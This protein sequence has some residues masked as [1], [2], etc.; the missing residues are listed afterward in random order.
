MK[1][2]LTYKDDKSDKFWNI[3]VSGTSFTVT[4][5]KTGT[6]GQT[7]TKTFGSEEECQKEAEKLLNEKLKKGYAEGD[8]ELLTGVL[9]EVKPAAN[10]RQNWES[11]SDNV[12]LRKA[13]AQSFAHLK[14]SAPFADMLTK[15]L[16]RVVGVRSHQKTLS[17][18]FENEEKKFIVSLSAGK[19]SPVSFGE[20]YMSDTGTFERE[21]LENTS[22][23]EKTAQ[24]K[25]AISDY[26]D[27]WLYHPTA[28]T[29]RKIPAI[30]LI[31][32][33]GGDVS[34]PY[35][36]SAEEIFLRRLAEHLKIGDIPPLKKVQTRTPSTEIGVMDL[37]FKEGRFE[38]PDFPMEELK[39][40]E[41]DI[42]VF[43][44]CPYFA[45]DMTRF[46]RRQ[47]KD[48]NN[49]WMLFSVSPDC[50]PLAFL[51]SNDNVTFD[52]D[53]LHNE[54]A[55]LI[56]PKWFSKYENKSVIVIDF[57]DVSNPKMQTHK[58][59][60]KVENVPTNGARW[61][62]RN[63]FI[64]LTN[65]TNVYNVNLQTGQCKMFYKWTEHE[66]MFDDSGIGIQILGDQLYYYTDKRV[67]V[68]D[69]T[70]AEEPKLVGKLKPKSFTPIDSLHS[71]SVLIDN[72]KTIAFFPARKRGL[73]LWNPAT[74][75]TSVHLSEIVNAKG[76]NVVEN[77]LW[78]FTGDI[79]FPRIF[80]VKISN[81]PTAEIL[82]FRLPEKL[83]WDDVIGMS[84]GK[85][86]VF[87]LLAQEGKFLYAF[88]NGS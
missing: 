5:G 52:Y 21:M 17:V 49:R 23:A 75:K 45:V 87:V 41:G 39:L 70:I 56:L 29:D 78:F 82:S 6:A 8:G 40:W 88:R 32:H 76:I 85:D 58:I 36:H 19:L 43:A 9:S 10:N 44:D 14:L 73:V 37:D 42:Y 46:Y 12:V 20:L 7:Q 16:D 71:K 47:K 53:C 18:E 3:E 74:N 66:D 54:S 86:Y 2:H 57:E 81:L 61:K 38:V 13:L 11:F 25:V 63:G 34:D 15:I 50:R 77:E 24:I 69:I 33:A 64:Y 26:A 84:V 30:C 65:G 28:K 35:N 22:L 68:Y 27:W 79:D 62:H 60:F 59:E 1:H 80:C 48:V 55:K 31:S 67:V 4:Y 72:E 83:K 51:N